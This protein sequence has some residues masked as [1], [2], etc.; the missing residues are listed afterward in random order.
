MPR[1]SDYRD[2]AVPKVVPLAIDRY[3]RHPDEA[4]NGFGR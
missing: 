3:T 4:L 1:L 2:T